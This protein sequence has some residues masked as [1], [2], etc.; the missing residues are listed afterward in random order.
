MWERSIVSGQ[1]GVGAPKATTR[2][3]L[4]TRD[5]VHQPNVKHRSSSQHQAVSQAAGLHGLIEKQVCSV[6]QWS[7]VLFCDEQ[8]L[9]FI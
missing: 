3:Q 9:H 2:R 6:V 4:T 5:E 7:T 1:P 8:V